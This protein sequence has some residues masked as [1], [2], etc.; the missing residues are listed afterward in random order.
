MHPI[1]ELV[2]NGAIEFAQT[3]FALRHFLV[4]Q[5]EKVT[6]GCLANQLYSL[7][8]ALPAGEKIASRNRLGY[9]I[10]T[11]GEEI[12]NDLAEHLV[13]LQ[14]FVRVEPLLMPQRT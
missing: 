6:H 7:G 4:G 12:E 9:L 3:L 2:G 14:D 13:L 1:F 11:I 5:A 8:D 10:G